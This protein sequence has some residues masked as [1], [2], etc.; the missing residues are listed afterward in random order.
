MEAGHRPRAESPENVPVSFEQLKLYDEPLQTQIPGRPV[1][2]MA[3][4]DGRILRIGS[5]LYARQ[6]SGRFKELDFEA[7]EVKFLEEMDSNSSLLAIASRRQIDES[8]LQQVR[9]QFNMLYLDPGSACA[10]D[11]EYD[12]STSAMSSDK[13]SNVMSDS[14]SDTSSEISDFEDKDDGH[15]NDDTL[16]TADVIPEIKLEAKDEAYPLEDSTDFELEHPQSELDECSARES[17]SEA[18]TSDQG[19]GIDD[20]RAWSEFYSSDDLEFGDLEQSISLSDPLSIRSS[21]KDED[22]DANPFDF[23]LKSSGSSTKSPSSISVKSNVSGFFDTDSDAEHEYLIDGF[24]AQGKS[25][26]DALQRVSKSKQ[27]CQLSIFDTSHTTDPLR[28]IF[29]FFCPQ[30]G[31]LFNSP[32]VFHPSGRL[33]VW[34]IGRDE[35]LFANF[36]DSEHGNTYFRRCFGYADRNTCHVSVQ[37][38]FSDNGQFLHLACVDGQ[39]HTN[40]AAD[41]NLEGLRMSVF[42]YRF[43]KGKLA[44]S[45]PK[46]IQRASTPLCMPA[47][48]D[49]KIPVSPLPYTFTWTEKHVY[50]TQSSRQLRIFRVPLFQWVEKEEYSS[51]E[52][53]EQ[54]DGLELNDTPDE[55][56]FMNCSSRLFLPESAQRRPIHFFP[57]LAPKLP[58]EE[59]KKPSKSQGS[60]IVATLVLSS[61]SVKIVVDAKNA[62]KTTGA[63]RP[64]QVVYLTAGDVGKWVRVSKEVVSS[65]SATEEKKRCWR[66]GKLLAKCEKFDR[67]NDCQIEPYVW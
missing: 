52:D 56:A 39:F 2:A 41:R 10:T 8:D 20:E 53:A 55:V 17:Y 15:G 48:F 37:V 24:E 36:A 5:K 50:A 7:D 59:S 60:P 6:D 49:G 64:P 47:D 35:L 16:D 4:N 66:G 45:P 32:P 14:D 28:H 42:T 54:P 9:P 67:Y 11:D 51:Q 18:S 25:K 19:D 26:R 29:K 63:H 27:L 46:L 22:E 57:L 3:F 30:A 61:E 31:L 40:S 12:G 1:A 34:P 23:L 58:K 13:S 62:S 33:L 65:Q 43:S 38:K 44:R 21:E